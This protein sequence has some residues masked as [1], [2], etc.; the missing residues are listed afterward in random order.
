MA[1]GVELDELR[2]RCI[3]IVVGDQW[4]FIVPHTLLRVRVCIPVIHDVLIKPIAV[5]GHTVQGRP[6]VLV[7]PR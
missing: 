4:K 1:V 6:L 2:G 7:Y 3:A 5:I